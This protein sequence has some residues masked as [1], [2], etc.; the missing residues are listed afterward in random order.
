MMEGFARLDNNEIKS[1]SYDGENVVIISIHKYKEAISILEQNQI[2]TETR[3]VI[4]FLEYHKY[5]LRKRMI[6]ST[7]I[8]CFLKSRKW[9]KEDYCLST[10]NN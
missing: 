1:P 7:I 5:F 4:C 8:F 3:E 6:Y 9:Q 10:K 2:A